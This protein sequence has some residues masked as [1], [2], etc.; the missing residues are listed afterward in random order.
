MLLSIKK[1]LLLMPYLSFLNT[2]TAFCLDASIKS[3]VG[4][5]SKKIFSLST[6][7]FFTKQKKRKFFQVSL[8]DV[9]NINMGKGKKGWT[10]VREKLSRISN[11][12]SMLCVIDCTVLPVVTILLPLIG[13]GASSDQTK[14]LHE[15]GHSVALFFVLPV[16][17]LAA[18]MNYLS[19]KNVFLASLATLGLTLIYAANGHGGPILSLLPH[20]LACALHCGTIL[21][22]SVNI[23]GC[24]LLL[25]SN[26]FGHRLSC[27]H[28]R[29]GCCDKNTSRKYSRI[30]DFF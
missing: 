22:K 2:S 24:A 7:H 12:A 18:T 29:G 20:E 15:L 25:S 9:N 5:T 16:G 10:G 1:L 23:V 28:D 30:D 19:S 11:V 13:L 8:G 3:P 21:H 27:N 17:G 6:S 4:S 14:L 26:Y